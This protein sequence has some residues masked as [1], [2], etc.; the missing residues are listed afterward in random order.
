[1]AEGG[2]RLYACDIC[3]QE[4]L[5]EDDMRSHVLTEHIEGA[6][7]CPF[8]DLEGTTVEE[9]NLHVNI[10]HLD[11]TPSTDDI[12][13]MDID[14]LS[15][16]SEP[17]EPII[18]SPDSDGL[19]SNSNYTNGDD[20]SIDTPPLPMEITITEPKESPKKDLYGSK[21][22][23]ESPPAPEQTR[24][25]AKLY[26]NVPLS[27]RNKNTQAE[28]IDNRQLSTAE[29]SGAVDN[30]DKE[31]RAFF[32]PL[33]DWVTT[34]P[35]EITRHVNDVHLDILSP[36]KYKKKEEK[37][38]ENNIIDGPS[39]SSSSY[40]C[41]ICGMHTTDSRSLEVHVNTK[42]A[43]I[44]SPAGRPD[45]LPLSVSTDSVGD[46]LCCPVC[47]M[48]FSDTHDLAVHVDG[49][50][51]G[52]QTP[53]TD[54]I[55]NLLAQELERREREALKAQE[56]QEFMKLQEMYGMNSK[57]NYKRQAE[58][59]LDKAVCNGQ[60]SISD[61]YTR[62]AEIL[63]SSVAGI[64]DGH[65]CTKG[66]LGR[67]KAYYKSCTNSPVCRVWLCSPCDHFAASY[68]DKGWG[69]GYRNLQMLLS[70]LAQNPTYEQVLFNGRAMIPSIPKIQ[71]LIEAAWQKG[72]DLQGCEQLGGKVVNTTKWIGATEIVATL[73]SLKVK[74][75]LVDFHGPAGK[76][77]THPRLFEWVRD[78]F[79]DTI[80]F[81]PPLYLQHQGHSRTIIGIEELKDGNLRLLLFDPSCSKKQMQQF[82]GDI[83]ANLMR[84]IRRSLYSMKAK[85]Y[86]I[87]AALG[88]L[89]DQEYEESKLLKSD[90]IH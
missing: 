67:L 33:C 39:T 31:K 1:M 14:D 89:T 42:H 90:R 36:N 53:V 86:Q 62:K 87:V 55:D 15:P 4:G 83:D 72:F 20:H 50:F 10:E 61:Y 69:C 60:L 44:L 74:C 65:S 46:G 45:A 19:L 75:Q 9:M 59:N 47:G 63:Q 29:E 66:I 3:G 81:K 13:Q 73:S 23:T 79:H 37:D 18:S 27:Q 71:R 40:E 58:K 57:G 16:S 56:Q 52:D 32:C 68:G 21:S 12:A 85:Q 38:E 70:C 78:Y 22:R 43:D 11:F 17:S 28:E 30:C 54:P 64:D 34:S 25:R 49:H 7:S 82:M 84:S 76:D 26:L 24:K 88:V 8:C 80:D 77:G 6:V 41:P 2:F 51:S 5:S 48:E 35:G